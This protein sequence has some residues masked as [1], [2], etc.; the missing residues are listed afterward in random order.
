M[1]VIIH[2]PSPAPTAPLPKSRRR[3]LDEFARKLA[4]MISELQSSGIEG[5]EETMA[6]LNARGITRPNGKPFTFGAMHRIK[7]RIYELGLGPRPRTVSQAL[8][9]RAAKIR[10]KIRAEHPDWFWFEA[11][12]DPGLKSV[13]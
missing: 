10:A 6:A 2:G 1:P 12:D 5:V 8:S 4:A 13:Q 7:W 9:T 3:P 11:I